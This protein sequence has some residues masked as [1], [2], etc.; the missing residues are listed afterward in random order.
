MPESLGTADELASMLE[1][2][3]VGEPDG[4]TA[5]ALVAE[6]LAGDAPESPAPA[7]V[8][9]ATP[10]PVAL[11]SDA[12]EPAAL[13]P[14]A[15]GAEGDALGV[16]VPALPLGTAPAGG[17]YVVTPSANRRSYPLSRAWIS[18]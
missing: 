6:L 11:E 18:A 3:A 1:S 2:E 10:V 7:T 4:S 17:A 15:P 12:L 16:A 8:E 13:E 5:L 14:A 9:P